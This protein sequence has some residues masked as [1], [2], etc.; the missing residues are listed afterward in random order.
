ML[1]TVLIV[2]LAPCPCGG[3]QAGRAAAASATETAPPPAFGDRIEIIS[4]P[5]SISI[6]LRD[7]DLAR[8]AFENLR[9][10]VTFLDAEGGFIDTFHLDYSHEAT[11]SHVVFTRD[12]RRAYAE[13]VLSL[14]DGARLLYSR[15]LKIPPP[16][17]SAGRAVLIDETANLEAGTAFDKTAAPAIRLPDRA[18][19]EVWAPPGEM[20]TV[21]I[22]ASRKRVA[23]DFT[24]P[25]AGKASF[26]SRQ[27]A[28]PDDKTK[29][30][31]YTPVNSDLYD[32]ETGRHE[33]AFKYMVEIPIDPA[34]VATE[35]DSV[36]QVPAEALR[37]HMT[38]EEVEVRRLG[39]QRITGNRKGLLG[40]TSSSTAIDEDGNPYFVMAYRSPIRFNVR[41]GKWEAPPVNIHD[42]LHPR[43]PKLA[44]L[45][46]AEEKVVE[47]R[48]DFSNCIFYHNRRI[49]V[50]LSRYAVFG[51]SGGRKL[52]MAGVVSIP[53]DHW[54][55]KDA[56][57][58]A[59]RVNA[60]SWP[61]TDISLWSTHVKPEDRRRKVKFIGAVG[62]RFCL[63][64]YHWNYF[65][66]MEV[67][68]DG[69]TKKLK[70]I[71]TF[72]GKPIVEFVPN[73]IRWLK[74]GDEVLGLRLH[75]KVEGQK[76]PRA[77]FLAMDADEFTDKLPEKAQDVSF[78]FN[79]K[80]Y[81]LNYARSYGRL[82]ADKYNVAKRMGRPHIG[83]MLTLY[84]D[85]ARRM[86][87]HPGPHAEIIARMNASSMG[88][89]YYLV[90]TPGRTMELLGNADYP[91]YNF[92]RYDCSSGAGTVRKTFL[93][94]DLG[95][96]KV[97]LGLPAGMGPYCHHWFREGGNDVLH[98]AGYT[99]VA[100]LTYRVQGKLP[101]RYTVRKLFHDMGRHLC[102]DG[103][104]DAYI[105][106]FRDMLP[107][108][109]DKVFV[110]GTNQAGR[111]G[112]AYSGGLMYYHRR[113]PRRL[114]KLSKMSRSYKTL[115]VTGRLRG[116]PGG[117]WTQDIYLPGN[118]SATYAETLPEDRRP[119]NRQPRIFV[120]EDRGA[121]GVHDLY[122]FTLAAEKAEG[123]SVSDVL[124][125]RNGLY[126]LVLMGDNTL[127]TF[128]PTAGQ[129]VDA[130]T[131][132]GKPVGFW[133]TRRGNTL[134]ALPDGTRMICLYDTP[135]AAEG[136]EVP[137]PTSAVFDHLDVD[138]AGRIGVTPLLRSTFD[139]ARR[140]YG[141]M[142]FLYDSEKDDGS[143]DLVIGPDSRVPEGAV[144]IIRDFLPPRTGAVAALRAAR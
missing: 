60:V 18:G 43:K 73:Q 136:D 112:T 24:L 54:D 91:V 75:A 37:I 98:Y 121:G 63:M 52:F 93:A 26:V 110:T 119:V 5:R 10:T 36:I 4:T 130:V 132:A 131:L 86:R 62:N 38:S 39:K 65:W 49:W 58:K 129:F 104:P 117:A 64:A 29:Y 124:A 16:V 19:A 50:L 128:D 11:P 74:Q 9:G 78:L 105:K 33:S 3:G 27:T 35:G 109:G 127:L 32:P 95:A 44:D 108:L 76:K 134:L 139:E 103:A 21:D 70:Q 71:N 55:D 90:A 7:F 42:F 144:K 31:I 140:F 87:E 138:A 56:F 122:G 69:S 120:Y 8:R 34:W 30:S 1:L 113:T 141:P 107:G 40:Q 99:G 97:R 80:T 88:P 68:E 101:E 72:G 6:G 66:V 82:T 137:A 46:Y 123:V 22:E 53:I 48:T 89:E 102:V 114:Y 25:I 115:A 92:A 61:D 125:S 142:A 83:G 126:L 67:N 94:R 23:A 106:W 81:L 118:F 77:V 12:G 14:R 17:E 135:P 2:I 84:Y 51:A 28:Y 143:Y 41:K 20:R 57:E 96:V 100:S 116:L 47:V 45:P 15:R 13:A 85:A 59:I 133:Y 79:K 111:G